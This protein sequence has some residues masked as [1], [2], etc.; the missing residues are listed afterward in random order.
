MITED[1]ARQ[2]VSD[3]V[4]FNFPYQDDELVIVDEETIT[5]DYGWIFFSVNKKYL[6]TGNF[7]DMIVGRGP[8]LFEKQTG[9]I[10][11]FGTALPVEQY[12]E[13][14]EKKLLSIAE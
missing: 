14:Y 7:R 11:P 5:K 6:E 2:I 3:Y 13:D 4:N 10:I 1:E 9:T 8:V 12:L